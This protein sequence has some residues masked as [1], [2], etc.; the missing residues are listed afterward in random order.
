MC[1]YLIFPGLKMLSFLQ[2]VFLVSQLNMDQLQ[3]HVD[4]LGFFLFIIC[5]FLH[6]CFYSS[7]I[8]FLLQMIWNTILESRMP[9]V[10]FCLVRILLDICAI[11]GSIQIQNSFIYA[12]GED[13]DGDFYQNCSKSLSGFWQNDYF[14]NVSLGSLSI[15]Q[16]LFLCLSSEICRLCYR[17]IFSPCLGLL[18]AT[19]FSWGLLLVSILL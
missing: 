18:L 10:L 13:W 17:Y 15:F 1:R 4:M 12:F 7:T 9:L 16:Y 8:W 5:H 14:H 11:C 2:Y 19:L 6:V 3:L